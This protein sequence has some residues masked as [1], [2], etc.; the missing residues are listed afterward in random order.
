[1]PE[2][3]PHARR[4][5]ARQALRP[6]RSLWRA[7]SSRSGPARSTRSSARTAPGKSTLVKLLAG[8]YQPTAGEMLLDGQPF[9]PRTPADA[10]DAGIAVIY[11]EPT[12]FPDLS[13]AENVFMGRLLTGRG[14][15]VS[16]RAMRDRTRELL[17]TL[18]VEIDPD[19][20]A[21]GLSIADQQL[22]EIVKAVS[23]DAKLLVM[24]EPTA[25]L[26]GVEVDRLFAVARQ[27]RDRGAAVVFISHRFDEIFALCDRITVM[28]DGEHVS[29]QDTAATD[30][31]D[32]RPADG[33]AVR[34]HDVPAHRPDA[35]RRGPRGRRADPGRHVRRHRPARARRGD[36]RHRRASWAP[37]AA[38]WCARC[39]ASTRTTPG[40]SG[41][42]GAVARARTTPSRP[43]AAAS[44]SSRRTAA[45]RGCT[46]TCR[47]P[48]TSR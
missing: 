5:R 3:R 31:G 18:G 22:V 1:M 2:S 39:S 6:G 48:G 19:R 40:P 47:W 32:D 37:G 35:R 8:V 45:S 26:S 43:C 4:P 7:P 42:T 25:A 36:P 44:R 11:Q 15:L 17:A 23:L 27:L 9:E 20:P 41:S 10:R 46:P 21:L 13:V 38:R 30:V 14:G 12:L 24:D 16:R 28:R 33:R 29:T 34:R